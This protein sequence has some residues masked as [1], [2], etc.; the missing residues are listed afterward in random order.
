MFRF[1]HRWLLRALV[2]VFAIAAFS[3]IA[4]SAQLSIGISV[5]FGPPA[6]PYYV[7][8]PCPRPDYIWS[9]GYWAWDPTEG[10]YYWVPGTWVPAPQ[11]GL[12]W[13]PG[14]WA[15]SNGVYVFNRGYW[16]PQVGYY[17]GI[18]YGYGYY[19]RGYAGGAWDHGRFRYNTAVTNVN[20]TYV[21]NV[22]VNRTVVVNHWNRVSYNGGRG[23]IEA[24]PTRAQLAVAHERR[25][26]A[27]PVQ[28]QHQRVAAQDR[29]NFAA[30]NHGRPAYAA[31]AHPL[32]TANRPAGARPLQSHDRATLVHARPAPA[33]HAAPQAEDHAAPAP[34]YHAAPQ[35]EHHAAPAPAYHAA[36]QAE[37]HAAPAPAYHAAPQAEHRAAPAPA[38]HAAPAPHYAAPQAHAAPQQAPARAPAG[39][40]QRREDHGGPPR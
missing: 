18:N 6:I 23:G 29:R 5:S 36:P 19:G 27:T 34:A 32:S 17:G 13:T 10:G 24:R 21:R 3:P 11:P 37:H 30:I 16:A 12:Y 14:Y 15:W 39:G 25:S 1:A 9:P 20:R 35:A 2:A 28:L 22:Y 4:A 38:Y 33:Y 8:P 31:V 26:Y 7:Q 40:D